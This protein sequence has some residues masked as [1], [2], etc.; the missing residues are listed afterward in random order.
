MLLIT[1]H[2]SR[3]MIITQ[4]LQMFIMS[5]FNCNKQCDFSAQGPQCAIRGA[6]VALATVFV[7]MCFMEFETF[8]LRCCFW[9]TS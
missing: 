6:K 7:Y 2:S 5:L 8:L 1:P 3:Y 9:L 4:Q